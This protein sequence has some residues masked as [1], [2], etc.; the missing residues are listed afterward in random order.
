MKMLHTQKIICK[1][2]AKAQRACSK[3]QSL[4]AL[5]VTVIQL[6]LHLFFFQETVAA[7]EIFFQTEEEKKKRDI[8]KNI[9]NQLCQ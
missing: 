2:V 3:C 6:F 8:K 4:V 1:H 9:T 7:L 5:Q